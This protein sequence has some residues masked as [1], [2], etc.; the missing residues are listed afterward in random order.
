MKTKRLKIGSTVLVENSIQEQYD[1]VLMKQD[2]LD[3]KAGE[4]E[5]VGL[6]IVSIELEPVPTGLINRLK[7]LVS[8]RFRHST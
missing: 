8:S 2:I 3:I 5:E 4:W 7:S 1:Y 6:K